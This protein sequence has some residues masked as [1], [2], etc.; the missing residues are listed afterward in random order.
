MDHELSPSANNRSFGAAALLPDF[1]AVPGRKDG[2]VTESD[3]LNIRSA[4]S[5][6]EFEQ[7]AGNYN[8]NGP[9]CKGITDSPGLQRQHNSFRT[10]VRYAQSQPASRWT[11]QGSGTEEGKFV[12]QRYGLAGIVAADHQAFVSPAQPWSS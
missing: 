11:K 9:V 2:L 6:S 3:K 7:V 4:F 12:W 8:R 5:R 10:G 1:D